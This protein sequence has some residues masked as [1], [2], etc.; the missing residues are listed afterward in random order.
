MDQA[1]ETHLKVA[2]TQPPHH[3][4]HSRIVHHTHLFFD[5]AIFSYYFSAISYQGLFCRDHPNVASA[6]HLLDVL[7]T[8]CLYRGRILPTYHSDWL[9]SPMCQDYSQGETEAFDQD[10]VPMDQSD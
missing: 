4:G 10:K 1:C 8:V 7:P 3:L 6:F 9:S 2:P 5:Q